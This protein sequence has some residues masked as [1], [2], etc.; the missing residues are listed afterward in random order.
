MLGIHEYI[1]SRFSNVCARPTGLPNHTY[2]GLDLEY[3]Y[4]ISA[5]THSAKLRYMTSSIMKISLEYYFGNISVPQP[6]D[7]SC[8]KSH[9]LIGDLTTSEVDRY[10]HVTKLEDVRN[11]LS[12]FGVT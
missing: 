11:N 4:Q 10:V 9:W 12:R 6:A 7:Y 1:Y 5:H 2:V 3:F 8:N